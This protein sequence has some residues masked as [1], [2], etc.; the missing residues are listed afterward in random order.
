MKF[1]KQLQTETL[2][3]WR[4]FYMN[5]RR[6]KRAIKRMQMERDA[7]AAEAQVEDGEGKPLLADRKAAEAYAD[8]RNAFDEELDR[9]IDKVDTFF[10]SKLTQCTEELAKLMQQYR[11]GGEDI[12]AAGGRRK[13][14]A[15]FRYYKTSNEESPDESILRVCIARPS[16]SSFLSTMRWQG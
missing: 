16:S 14:E 3:E 11:L 13:S 8:S 1:G 6:L 15:L 9:E 4:E 10:T 2:P 5:Y 7:G 12:S